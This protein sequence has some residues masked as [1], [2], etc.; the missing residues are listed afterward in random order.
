MN[1]GI[2]IHSQTGNTLSVAEKLKKSLILKGHD[3]TLQQVTD[4][5]ESSHKS[6]IQ[7]QTIPTIEDYDCLFFGAPVWGYSLSPVMKLYLAQLLTLKD[8]RVG[9]FVTEF[10]PYSWMGGSRAVNQM[11]KLCS[12]KGA[13]ASKIGVV[14]WSNRK[15]S[16]K[17][18]SVIENA[19]NLLKER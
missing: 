17:T 12:Q 15:R 13:K 4:K 10:F 8:K 18:D 16:N 9:C 5:G 19:I 6:K 3:V 11:I 14:N 7:L 2:I 1:I